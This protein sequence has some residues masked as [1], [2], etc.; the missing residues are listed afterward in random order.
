MKMIQAGQTLWVAILI[1]MPGVAP[2]AAQGIFGGLTGAAPI[3]ISV[4]GG[5]A[6]F[7]ALGEVEG[8]LV[9]AGSP[10]SPYLINNLEL[11]AETAPLFGIAVGWPASRSLNVRLNGSFTATEFD[12]S[13]VVARPPESSFATLQTVGGLGQLYVST[14]GV[15]LLWRL[16]ERDQ[17]VG[18]YATVGAGVVIWDLNALND[19][20]HLRPVTGVG[21]EQSPRTEVS[22]SVALGIGA[23]VRFEDRAALRLEISD[24]IAANALRDGDF[25]GGADFTGVAD[26]SEIVH[27]I[28]VVIGVVVR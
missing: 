24:R 4:H 8:Q 3:Q 18:P 27:Q 10:E 23:D 17:V 13:G 28:A 6:G 16:S 14:V 2:A 15:D 1:A 25:E 11:T 20:E 12:L 7:T 9:A 22:P 21:F 26:A 19:F 5:A